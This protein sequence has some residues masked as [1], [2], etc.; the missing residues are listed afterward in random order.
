MLYKTIIYS[1]RIPM[2]STRYAIALLLLNLT[3]LNAMEETK[4]NLLTP[5]IAAQQEAQLSAFCEDATKV[6]QSNITK[7]FIE[8]MNNLERAALD[9]YKQVI[10]LYDMR[11]PKGKLAVLS[12]F[13]SSS[14]NAKCVYPNDIRDIMQNFM[15]MKLQDLTFKCDSKDI[16]ECFR[17]QL[18]DFGA[19]NNIDSNHTDLIEPEIADFICLAN[20]AYK[21]DKEDEINKLRADYKEDRLN[22][23]A[24]IAAWFVEQETDGS[25]GKKRPIELLDDNDNDADNDNN[26]DDDSD[27]DNDDNYDDDNN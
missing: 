6:I 22:R 27:D 12:S 3:R 14:T 13:L 15:S 5:E 18:I 8:D 20:D 2:K 17:A 21:K 9:K 4:Y 23:A 11:G 10:N 25:C 19:K 24:S 16:M 7:A 1:E 26:D